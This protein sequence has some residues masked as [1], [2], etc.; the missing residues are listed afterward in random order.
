[1]LECFICHCDVGKTLS[2]LFSHLKNKHSVHEHYSRYSCAQGQCC[3]TFSNK[4]TLAAHIRNCHT[5]D[6]LLDTAHSGG[7][8]YEN[9]D[10]ALD[11]MHNDCEQMS[12]DTQDHGTNFES[13]SDRPSKVDISQL[14][15]EF[16]CVAKSCISSLSTVNRVMTACQHMFEVIADEITADLIAAG[17]NNVK[18]HQKLA[19]Y[20]NPFLGLETDYALTMHRMHTWKV[21]G[22]LSGLSHM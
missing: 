22:C 4:Y 21:L 20:R 6:L 7:E 10:V 5:E 9:A 16:L 19:A 15:M 13:G 17:V 2:A 1:M 14:A 3:Q 18:I 12:V 8:V 11:E